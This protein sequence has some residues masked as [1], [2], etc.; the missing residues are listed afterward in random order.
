MDSS[1]RFATWPATLPHV[2]VVIPAWNMGRYVAR[3][4]ASALAQTWPAL[5][6]L[7]VDDGSTDDTRAIAEAIAARDS[8]VT[9]HSFPNGG[10]ARARN[11]G[12]EL[13]T[14]TWVAFLDADDLWHPTK[15]EKQLTALQTHPPEEGWVGCYALFR[16]VDDHD[17]VIASGYGAGKRG[18]FFYDHLL[19]NHVGNGSSL[20]VLREAALAVGGFDPSYAEARIGGSEDFDFQLRLLMR[21]K[22]EYVPEYLVGYRLHAAQMS[23]DQTRM[24]LGHIAVVERFVHAAQLDG[25]QAQFALVAANRNAAVAFARSGD[26]ANARRAARKLW[27]DDRSAALMFAADRFSFA[28][29]RGLARL[30][31]R[32]GSHAR[33]KSRSWVFGECDPL[34]G[35]LPDGR[36]ARPGSPLYPAPL[37]SPQ[38]PLAED[39]V[40]E[41]DEDEA[42]D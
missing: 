41:P 19:V 5:D 4:I 33:L 10:V 2:T 26:W 35:I 34:P 20:L 28:A 15:I 30:G 22:L 14:G 6:V 29:R 17:R 21:Y 11:R 39:E 32:W 40:E 38:G 16:M 36:Q 37:D 3:S 7:V 1:N 13:A 12:T 27:G 24:A 9:V 25:R 8:R 31:H 42:E 23:A 18:S